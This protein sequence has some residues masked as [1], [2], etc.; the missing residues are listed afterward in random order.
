MEGGMLT[1]MSRFEASKG[2]TLPGAATPAAEPAPPGQRQVK[3]ARGSTLIQNATYTAA[4]KYGKGKE[5]E[6]LTRTKAFSLC[7]DYAD[8]FR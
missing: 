5:H 7:R 8:I 1:G 3:A 4:K 6:T 2:V